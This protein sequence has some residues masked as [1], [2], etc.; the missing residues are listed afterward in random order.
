MTHSLEGVR[1]KNAICTRCGYP[2]GGV[3]I[4]NSVIVCP[5]CGEPVRFALVAPARHTSAARAGG[6]A[7]GLLV[8]AMLVV[9][10]L[11]GAR[12]WRAGLG[13]GLTAALC[14]GALVWGRD[15]WRRSQGG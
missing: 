4:H 15:A 3:P 11:M 12:G 7:A 6:V 13:A 14:I 9:W 5:E 1:P 2:F 10:G 8:C